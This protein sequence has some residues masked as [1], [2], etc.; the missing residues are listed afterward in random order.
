[1]YDIWNQ[2]SLQ[3]SRQTTLQWWWCTFEIWTCSKTPTHSGNM[4]RVRYST[5]EASIQPSRTTR[6]LAS[7]PLI[8]GY[9]VKQESIHKTIH[10]FTLYWRITSWKLNAYRYESDTQNNYPPLQHL[11]VYMYDYHCSAYTQQ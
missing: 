2:L 5:L 4:D 8:F 3:D 10:W 1:M 11:Q 9:M 7:G 6:L